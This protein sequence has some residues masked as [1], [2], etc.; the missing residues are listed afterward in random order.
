MLIGDG[1][2]RRHQGRDPSAPA[3]EPG[4]EGNQHAPV[5]AAGVQVLSRDV[6]EVSDVLRE[7]RPALSL[8]DLV[9]RGQVRLCPATRVLVVMRLERMRSF[10]LPQTGSVSGTPRFSRSCGRRSGISSTPPRR[11]SAAQLG[12]CVQNRRVWPR[13]IPQ[14]SRVG[15]IRQLDWEG[16]APHDVGYDTLSST[17]QT[18]RELTGQLLRLGFRR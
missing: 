15:E 10:T 1:R 4:G 5:M 14:D 9:S 11:L 18:W 17:S 7:Q 16:C 6:S 12:V 8:A 2:Y 13:P 3:R